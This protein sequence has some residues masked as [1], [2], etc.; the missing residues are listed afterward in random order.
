MNS[1][2]SLVSETPSTNVEEED[3]GQKTSLAAGPDRNSW[4]PLKTRR[5]RRHG[6]S[7]INL[8][9]PSR[10]RNGSLL[11][12]PFVREA[13]RGRKCGAAA[14][15]NRLAVTRSLRP[16]LRPAIANYFLILPRTLADIASFRAGSDSPRVTVNDTAP[17]SPPLPVSIPIAP[18]LRADR[19]KLS[20]R[21][22]DRCGGLVLSYRW[23][24]RYTLNVEN[25]SF[26]IFYRYVLLARVLEYLKLIV[27]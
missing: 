24:A 5:F 15:A 14:R 21:G 10:V 23:S 13:A 16:D 4:R 25:E 8:I 3:G 20:V 12:C 17:T 27:L 9:R 26:S 1:S 22:S 18:I 7:N 2:R 6:S 19:R 11:N